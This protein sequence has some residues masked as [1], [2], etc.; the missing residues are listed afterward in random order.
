M[1][2][3]AHYDRLWNAVN[4]AASQ[5][6]GEDFPPPAQA[7]ER[8]EVTALREEVTALRERIDALERAVTVAVSELDRAARAVERAAQHAQ[9]QASFRGDSSG[10]TT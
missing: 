5:S 9:A 7:P 10:Q 2:P 6:A 3:Y 1:V 8:H 4:L